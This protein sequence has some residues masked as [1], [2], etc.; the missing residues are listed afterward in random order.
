[1]VELQK[2]IDI[3]KNMQPKDEESKNEEGDSK[4]PNPSQGDQN[5]ESSK[6][7][8]NAITFSN[9]SEGIETVSEEAGVEV[10]EPHTPVEE[11]SKVEDEE[12]VPRGITRKTLSDKDNSNK[13]RIKK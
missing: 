6:K 12:Y 4:V 13:K 9:P 1:M 5:T 2:H 11:D 10:E 7:N 3:C 8:S